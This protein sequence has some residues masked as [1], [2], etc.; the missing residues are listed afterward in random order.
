MP[1]G[2]YDLFVMRKVK[3]FNCVIIVSKIS[4]AFCPYID[5]S[6]YDQ[7]E[8]ALGYQFLSPHQC[9]NVRKDLPATFC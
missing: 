3:L 6:I 9:L 7:G 8:I 5:L 1:G 2:F 4:I